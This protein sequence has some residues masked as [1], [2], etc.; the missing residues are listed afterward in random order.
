MSYRDY[1]QAASFSADLVGATRDS[2]HRVAMEVSSQTRDV[3]ASNEALAARGI[4]ATDAGFSRVEEGMGRL[5]EGIGQGMAALKNQMG[6][7][8]DQLSYDLQDV[9]GKLSDLKATF[10]WG[11]G[12]MLAGMGRMNDTLAELVKVAK[13]PAQTAAYEQYEIAR[14][15]F[16][17]GLYHECLESIDK[18]I[19]GDHA[20]TGYKLEWR[21]HQMKG[22]VFL[23]FAGGAF[24]L[25]DLP[26]AEE[27]FL[28]SARYAK[29]DYPEHAAQAF[30][31]AGWAA[32]CQGKLPE[33]L[34]HTEQALTI[35]PALGEALFQAA[36]VRVA[37][38]E[39]DKALDSLAKAIDVDPFYALKAAG[40]G[41]FLPHDR[42]LRRFLDTLRGEKFRQVQLRVQDG[43][44]EL[45]FWRNH[46]AEAAGHPT[47]QRM[48]VVLSGGRDLPLFDL[49]AVGQEL[50][51]NFAELRA[52]A[53]AAVVCVP[54]RGKSRQVPFEESYEAQE[55]YQVEESYPVTETYQ[56]EVVVKP[57]G[58]FRKAV[59]EWRTAT[60]TVM[61]TRPV[62][63]TR[64]VTRTRSVMRH[65]EV[66]TKDYFSGLGRK[67]EDAEVLNVDSAEYFL[68]RLCAV[69]GGA[70]EMGDARVAEF[71][72][73]HGEKLPVHNVTL[74]PFLL[75]RTPVTQAEWVA[76]M[77]ANPSHFK[78]ADRPVECVSWEQ[79]QTFLAK[80][81][82]TTGKSFR[83]PT[84]AEWEYAARSGG[85]NEEWA[86]TSSPEALGEYA[87]Y[88][89]NSGGE[90]QPVGQKKPNG[91]GLC[92]MSGNV[93]EWC[94]DWRGDYSPTSQR[95]PT[96]PPSGFARVSRGGSWECSAFG[97]NAKCRTGDRP[98]YAS[99]RLGF[100]L[101]LSSH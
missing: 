77:G 7:G 15:A 39:V 48:E 93:G 76:I 75:G 71:E 92:D 54:T 31:S 86:G 84:E 63:R 67:L 74:S 81:N 64:N 56:E 55:E 98:S 25:Q 49:L 26:R 73:I 37:Q 27:S 43:L 5:A 32:Y 50:E 60:R 94:Q 9:S 42:E 41:D 66:T 80:L 82:Q 78:G 46:D 34:G 72:A 14:D 21:F 45:E 11:F 57:G 101:A 83:L 28:L 17:Q 44:R 90:T 47:L 95:D 18:A 13:T 36:K 3:I 40:D 29:T 23:G 65:E 30:L 62:T 24:D 79:V 6:E 70:F 97:V 87:W 59:T 58:L 19:K 53:E 99:H 35:C 68:R 88:D 2:G 96:G 10:H 12:Q 100:R 61:R 89:K 8:F 91:L 85:K 22:T 38:G 69:P 51:T 16:R 20:S 4:A 33:A 1:L 52:A